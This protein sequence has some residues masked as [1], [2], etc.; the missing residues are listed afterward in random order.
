LVAKLEAGGMRV[1]GVLAPGIWRER[2]S[3]DGTQRFEKLGIENVLLPSKDR[4]LFA[5]RR[6]LAQKDN[7]LNPSS[8]SAQAGLGWEISAEALAKVN[9]HFATIREERRL[10]EPSTSPRFTVVDELGRLEL[11]F[12]GGLFEA[13]RL[14]DDGPQHERDHAI[15]VVR[16][17]LVELAEQRL[18]HAWPESKRI[19]PHSAYESMTPENGLV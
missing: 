19:T 10:A 11:E 2:H 9:R 17:R 8:E 5:R 6:D 15:V 4:I 16:S 1:E 14:L 12:G 18:A 3:E 13:L 7:Q